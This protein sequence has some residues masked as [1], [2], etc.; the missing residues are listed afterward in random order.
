MVVLYE[1]E[2]EACVFTKSLSIEAFVEEPAGI[3]EHSRFNNFDFWDGGVEDFHRCTSVIPIRRT[4]TNAGVFSLVVVRS[5]LS[6][7]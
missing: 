4:A 6:R 1:I 3:T 7:G 2:I 5:P